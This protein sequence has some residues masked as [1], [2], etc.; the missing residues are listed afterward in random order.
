M[1]IQW[2]DLAHLSHFHHH[3]DRHV[4]RLS[5]CY[6]HIQPVEILVASSTVV[7]QLVQITCGSLYKPAVLGGR[8]HE[9][10]VRV[11]L[12]RWHAQLPLCTSGR[13][14]ECLGWWWR[15]CFFLGGHCSCESLALH[16]YRPVDGA[17]R[18]IP[19]LPCNAGKVLV[20][21]ICSF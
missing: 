13:G 8:G 15:S 14:D 1:T 7:Q 5:N 11:T 6:A 21:Q 19:D 10:A 3:F 18:N 4:L 17:F 12:C 16:L 9:S 2:M 20:S